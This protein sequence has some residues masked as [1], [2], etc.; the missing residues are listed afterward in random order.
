MACRAWLA[1]QDGQPDEVIRLADQV[2]N[3][4]PSTINI[5]GAYRWVYL[6]PLIAARL[7]A[8][9][10]DEAVTAARQVLDPAQQALSDD[11]TAALEAA[12]DAWDRGE[13]GLAGQHL[14]SALRLARDRNYF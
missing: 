5:I 14:E 10:V 13:P 9:R 4:Q 8:G 2:A 6:F 1:W 3:Y 7:G 12:S 11:L